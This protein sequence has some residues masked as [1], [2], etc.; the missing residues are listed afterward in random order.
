M[1]YLRNHDRKKI[2]RTVLYGDQEFSKFELE[3]LH[4]SILQRLYNLKQLGFAD[5]VFPDAVHSRF[6]HV[7][8]VPEVAE[9]MARSLRDWLDRHPDDNFRYVLDRNGTEDRLPQAIAGLQ[10][11]QILDERIPV[12]RLMTLLHDVTHGAFGHTLEDEVLLFEEKHDNPERQ[13][14]F[15]DAVVAQL[16]Y[17]WVTEVRLRE[18]EP[19]VFESIASLQVDRKLAREWTQEIDHAL[20]K[21][22]ADFK[23][24]LVGDLLRL[25]LAMRLLL[26]LDLMHRKDAE[27][28]LAKVELLDN[29]LAVDAIT[30][31]GCKGRRMD[32][33]LHR[34]VFMIDMVGNTICADL[35]D[36]ARRDAEN[37]GLK[38]RFDERLIRYLSA[39]S[40]SDSLSPTR[41]PC[42][43]LAMQIFT[44]KMRHDVLSE[45]SAVLKARYL[46]NE[47]VLFHPTKCAA[48][49]M[50]GT[51]VQLLG[52]RK[53]PVWMQGLGDQEF[54]SALAHAAEDLLYVCSTWPESKA[55][56]SHVEEKLWPPS[57]RSK[58]LL[59]N[60]IEG[61]LGT[62]EQMSNK[63][64]VEAVRRRVAAAR[65]LMWRLAS[66]RYPKLAF[67]LRTGIEHSGGGTHLEVAKKYTQPDTRYELE[68]MVED[69][70][71]LPLGSLVIHCPTHR[72]SM[73]LAEVIVV[74]SDPSTAVHLRNLTRVLGDMHS[75]SAEGLAP[76]Q[77]EIRAIEDMYTSIWQLHVYL[78]LAWFDK[79]PLVQ[80]VLEHELGFPNDALL[81]QELRHDPSNVYHLLAKEC[82]DE[83]PSKLMQNAIE[84]LDEAALTM[85][86]LDST[87]DNPR[88]VVMRVIQETMGLSSSQPRLKGMEEE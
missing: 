83:I 50:L 82:R 33:V 14:R 86:R 42:I 69:K 61:I 13:C 1:D 20:K 58:A 46:V 3:L 16:L 53:I 11:A 66:R 26:R 27:A 21:K 25:D 19:E 22:P 75:Q 80:E 55:A 85:K 78:D 40:V 35:L 54:L 6:N 37:A 49:A 52:L 56:V 15:F 70:C 31:L 72:T 12:I 36:Y 8:G 44:D 23:E 68:R 24:A 81:K 64:Q 39:A 4:T 38:V 9:R 79:Q 5:R 34:D 32:L 60:C 45:M 59:G 28:G 62:G 43:R 73:K 87:A 77:E 88:E 63:D 67:R 74:G 71:H 41:H 57:Q 2:V 47:R 48:G 7:L 51:S 30:E 10:L 76:Y 18:P 17:F 84:R 65:L 29:L